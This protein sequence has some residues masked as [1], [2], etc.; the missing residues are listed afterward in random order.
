MAMSGADLFPTPR[1]WVERQYNV[2]HWTD[3]PR[4]GHF[5]E[6]EVPGLVAADL[7]AL[8]AGIA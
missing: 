6:R 3:L 5:L 2:V 8:F 7:R 4:G 1:E